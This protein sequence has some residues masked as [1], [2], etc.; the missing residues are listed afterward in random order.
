M[1][2]SG[3]RASGAGQAGSAG[4]ARGQGRGGGYKIALLKIVH[5]CVVGIG[6]VIRTAHGII[7]RRITVCG[8]E[9]ANAYFL[10]GTEGWF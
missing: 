3:P 5:M 7:V 8:F 6:K 4:Q 9:P 1:S 2:E 10:G